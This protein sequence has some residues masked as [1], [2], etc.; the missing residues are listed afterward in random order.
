MSARQ[1]LASAMLLATIAI[2]WF[3]PGMILFWLLQEHTR[4]S[5]HLHDATLIRLALVFGFAVC[6]VIFAREVKRA[7]RMPEYDLDDEDE[8]YRNPARPDTR[9]EVIDTED[10]PVH[11]EKCTRCDLELD[12]DGKPQGFMR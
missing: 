10:G 8:F 7:P 9:I 3:L 6:L 12:L 4:L 1:L 5:A 2:A 11:I